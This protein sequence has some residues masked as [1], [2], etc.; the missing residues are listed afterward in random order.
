MT[1]ERLYAAF[2]RLYPRVFRRE[3]GD[4]MMEAFRDLHAA[5]RRSPVGFWCFVIVDVCYSAVR[6]HVEA[7]PFFVRWMSACGLGA[8]VVSGLANAITWGVSYFYHPYLEGLTVA[9]WSYGAL[10]GLGLGAVQAAALPRRSRTAARW[11]LATT[12]SAALGMPVAVAMAAVAGPVGAGLVLGGIVA[13]GQWLAL[14]THTQ[15][16]GWWM[17]AGAGALAGGVLS[18]G[19]AMQ[20]ALAGVNPLPNQLVPVRVLPIPPHVSQL[21]LGIA[22]MATTGLVVGALTARPVSQLCAE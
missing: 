1:A 8:V 22:I 14:R 7:T 16:V 10:L 2:L 19:V 13:T 20:R 21:A 11:V 3:Y 5:H 18:Y 4:A 15:R 17:S 6:Q 9:P 12:A